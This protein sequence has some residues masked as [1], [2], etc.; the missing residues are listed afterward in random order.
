MLQSLRSAAHSWVVKLLMILLVV[1]FAVW[2][3]GDMFRGH[4]EQRAVAKVGRVTITAHELEREFSASLQKMREQA[5]SALTAQEAR[6]QGL[7]DLALGSLIE[8]AAFDQEAARLGLRVDD[9]TAFRWM[10]RR[11]MFQDENGHFDKERWKALLQ[12]NRLAEKFI[13]ENERADAARHLIFDALMANTTVPRVMM[14]ALYK[15]RGQKR[16]FEVVTVPNDRQPEPAA[17]DEATLK[18]F[19]D[20]A[21]DRFMAPEFRAVTV[22]ILD[23]SSAAAES[24]V[25]DADVERAYE[26]RRANLATPERRDMAHVVVQDPAQAQ[27]LAK[28]AQGP[29]GFEAAVRAAGLK[30]VVLE[31]LEEGTIPPA[32]YTTVFALKIGDVSGPVK[33]PLGWH[34]ITL[35][36][37]HPST[38][39]SLDDVRASLRTQL[40]Q[41]RVGDALARRVNEL[42]DALAAGKTLESLKE[43]LGLRLVTWPAVDAEGRTP[44]GKSV[45]N[46][47]GRADIL[48][49]AFSQSAEETS[50]VLDDRQGASLVVRSD[51]VT[52]AH[53]R[54]FA[55]ARDEVR[56]AWVEAQ[57][58]QTA[59]VAAKEIEKALR[60]K[61]SLAT[62]AARPG[63]ETRL[64]RP[65]SALGDTDPGLPKDS[66]PALLA[67]KRG[68]V[69][70]IR[71]GGRFIVARLA[72]TTDVDPAQASP[73]RSQVAGS[74]VKDFPHEIL[75]QAL[76]DVNKRLTVTVHENVLNALRHRESAP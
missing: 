28:A 15:A 34:V 32:L 14:D 6:D 30:P 35:R 62:L 24:T 29:E 3:V 12:S 10:A 51:S 70:L 38:V 44:E 52:P 5:G 56:R 46:L 25:T 22:G 1:S 54:T 13:L 4:P 58:R 74:L 37:V 47:P 39:P 68:D 16:V 59:E 23:A 64:S 61:A 67:L 43:P 21:Q 31:G 63:V 40:E 57:K 26:D 55:E 53:R 7:L 60:E 69:T 72:T 18:A 33:S 65:V 17:P 8:H 19:Y 27:A 76:R 49:T 75:D 73:E 66:L 42:D 50:P 20:A 36:A 41:E 11:P 45:E 2:G 48:R 9:K 71:D